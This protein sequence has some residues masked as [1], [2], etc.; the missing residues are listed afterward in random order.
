M[1]FQL[2][3]NSTAEVEYPFFDEGEW[4]RNGLRH[5]LRLLAVVK[6]WSETNELAKEVVPAAGSS[7]PVTGTA[8]TGRS[9]KIR[10]TSSGDDLSTGTIW[11]TIWSTVEGS[12]ALRSSRVPS[13][14]T[15]AALQRDAPPPALTRGAAKGTALSR[16]RS[17]ARPQN[18]LGIGPRN[19]NER[20]RCTIVAF[21]DRKR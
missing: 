13:V 17:H 21:L 15:T 6:S 18:I 8:S 16:S 14:E 10:V 7:G 1:G 2:V 9:S 11:S 19:P 5:G 4:A 3:R 20:R 12:P